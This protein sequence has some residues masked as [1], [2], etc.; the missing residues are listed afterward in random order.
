MIQRL[1]LTCPQ[2]IIDVS[3]LPDNILQIEDTKEG[4]KIEP[5]ITLNKSEK[6][7]IKETLMANNLNISKTAKILGITRKTLHNKLD[8]Y[9]DIKKLLKKKKN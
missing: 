4:S 3:N 9:N 5:G 7:L 1:I 8:K 6:I 2:T